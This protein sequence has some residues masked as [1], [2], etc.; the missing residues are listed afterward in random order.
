[1]QMVIVV[2]LEN[3]DSLIRPAACGQGING[4]DLNEL[5]V[6]DNKN[7]NNV[8]FMTNLKNLNA[9]YDCGIDQNGRIRGLRFSNTT[10]RLRTG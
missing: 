9:S 10:C 6:R 4:L 7:I 8:S 5:Y 2:E 3:H 1:M